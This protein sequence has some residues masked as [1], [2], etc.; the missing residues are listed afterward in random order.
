MV[1]A[2]IPIVLASRLCS[3]YLHF[4]DEYF[5]KASNHPLRLCAF[6]AEQLGLDAAHFGDTPNEIKLAGSTSLRLKLPWG[7]RP[8]NPRPVSGVR[9]VAAADGFRHRSWTDAGSYFARG[10]ARASHRHAHHCRPSNG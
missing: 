5:N 2:A 4:Q 10:T 3:C 1:D 9:G 6:V 8:L 7:F